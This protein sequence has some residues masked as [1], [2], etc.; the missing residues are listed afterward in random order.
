MQNTKMRCDRGIM[1]GK[2]KKKI[3]IEENSFAP[4]PRS[5]VSLLGTIQIAAWEENISK[6]R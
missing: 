4:T 6:R 3:G 5:G 2:P 1:T